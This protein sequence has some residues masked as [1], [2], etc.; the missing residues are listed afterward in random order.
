MMIVGIVGQLQQQHSAVIVA[1]NIDYIPST[2]PL[3]SQFYSAFGKRY[4]S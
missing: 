2:F 1:V 4:F 3:P